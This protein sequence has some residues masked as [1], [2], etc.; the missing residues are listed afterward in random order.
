VIPYGE[1]KVELDVYEADLEGLKVAEV[2][3]PS[4]D[5]AG[6]FQPPDWI[7]EEVTGDERYLNE[8]LATR[9]RPS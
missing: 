3:F 6:N 9:G 8:T 2:E 4:E 7:G 1:L 5:E